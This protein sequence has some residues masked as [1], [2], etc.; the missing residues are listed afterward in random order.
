MRACSSSDFCCC[1]SV[2]RRGRSG[3]PDELDGGGGTGE[4]TGEIAG[5]TAGSGWSTAIVGAGGVS[6]GG[7]GVGGSSGGH[8]ASGPG[9]SLLLTVAVVLLAAL[10]SAGL[11]LWLPEGSQ[12]G[13]RCPRLRNSASLWW[14][15]E[16]SGTPRALL[17]KRFILSE[18]GEAV[19][20]GS[21]SASVLVRVAW[22]FMRGPWSLARMSSASSALRAEKVS[23]TRFSEFSP[24]ALRAARFS[25]AASRWRAFSSMARRFSFCWRALANS[26]TKSPRRFL[27]NSSTPQVLGSSP[28]L[29]TRAPKRCSVASNRRARVSASAAA[30]SRK[31]V[32]TSTKRSPLGACLR[33][34]WICWPTRLILA[35]SWPRS[36]VHWG[37]EQRAASSIS[38][39]SRSNS[40]SAGSR[41]SH[42]CTSQFMR[43]RELSIDLTVA[44]LARA[45]SLKPKTPP[46]PVPPLR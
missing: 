46:R 18:L 39:K 3:T 35:L 32:M 10:S 7:G 20:G 14:A 31:G 28:K 41:S 30:R 26:A 19:L 40:M 37:S 17:T 24:A 42:H 2:G 34:A 12:E 8:F 27:K 16:P 9:L 6:A 13:F 33:R 38:G 5:D 15:A 44:S 36:E 21:P 4:R 11:L 29:R 45:S 1:P 23:L 25:A 43:L 22:R